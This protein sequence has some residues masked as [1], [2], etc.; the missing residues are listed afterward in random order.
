MEGPTADPVERRSPVPASTPSSSILLIEPTPALCSILYLNFPNAEVDVCSSFEEAVAHIPLTLYQVVICPQRLASRDQ[1]SLLYLNDLHHPCA[2][3]IVTTEGEEV[4]NVWQAINHGAL[5][6][7]HGTNNST[8]TLIGI[9]EPLLSL[10]RLRFSL[11]GRQ[12]WVSNFRHQL[13]RNAIHEKVDTLNSVKQDNRVMCE[14]TLT[15]IEGSMQAFQAQ[16]D[17]LTSQARQRMWES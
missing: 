15:A 6:F 7:M 14:Q 11:E 8:P 1:Y 3:F 2:P 5:G 12:K 13:R 17:H 16:A 4:A 10:Y 9:I